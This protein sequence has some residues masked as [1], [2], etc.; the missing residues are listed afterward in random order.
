[1]K[2]KAT[3]LFIPLFFAWSAKGQSCPPIDR[4]DMQFTDLNG[5][6]I[7][8]DTS[9][10]VFV[11]GVNGDD[12]DPGTM[13]KPVKTIPKAISIAK[14]KGRDVYVAKGTYTTATSFAVE[15]GVSMYGLFSGAP[16]WTRSVANKVTLTG[17]TAP[18]N[19][20]N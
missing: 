15:S 2:L 19:A 16:N 17:S 4:P 13:L 14:N 1:M 20:T 5:D 12:N 18:L 8:G 7:D 11:D 9:R 6:G 3:L 10:A